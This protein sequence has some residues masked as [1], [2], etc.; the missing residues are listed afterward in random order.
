MTACAE[1]AVR[2]G[3]QVAASILLDQLSSVTKGVEVDLVGDGRRGGDGEDLVKFCYIKVRHADRTR[4]A[5]A[6][7]LL[8][9]WP[10]PGRSTL[11]P[12]HQVEIDIL[13]PQALQARFDL[14]NRVLGAGIE[15]RRDEDFA[16]IETTLPK[17]LPDTFLIPVPLSRVD[18]AVAQLKRPTYGVLR[19][20]TLGR[21][22]DAEGECGNLMPIC[23]GQ[24]RYRITKPR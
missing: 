10:R 14:T 16:A 18:V 15:L 2:L 23:E 5:K 17:A 22:P 19:L 4:I 13:E 20:V 3:H 1:R 7:R 9:A 11:R 8:H 6:P 24:R 12:M 21:L